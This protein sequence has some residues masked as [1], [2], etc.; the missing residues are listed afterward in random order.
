M[1]GNERGR[2]FIPL[3]RAIHF[4]YLPH[5]LRNA[6]TPQTVT[7]SRRHVVSMLQHLQPFLSFAQDSYDA[8]GWREEE[9]SVTRSERPSPRNSLSPWLLVSEKSIM[10]ARPMLSRFVVAD[11][12]IIPYVSSS[13]LQGKL[14]K[15]CC[16]CLL[17]TKGIRSRNLARWCSRV[18]MPYAFGQVNQEAVEANP[19]I[20]DAD[21][22]KQL[23]RQ[24]TRVGKKIASRPQ[25]KT[26]RWSPDVQRYDRK[27]LGSPK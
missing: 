14:T 2:P 24:K 4:F 21:P 1:K 23:N 13:Y 3:C 25:V 16:S 26:P 17:S 11:W 10:D 18:R 12:T 19:S 22:L 8:K 6:P 5:Q 27:A 9:N 15:L 7:N 20:L